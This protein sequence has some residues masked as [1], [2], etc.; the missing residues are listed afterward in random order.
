M[1]QNN[2]ERQWTANDKWKFSFQQGAINVNARREQGKPEPNFL[3][4][5]RELKG[6][7]VWD[8]RSLGFSW[9]LHHK[10]FMGRWFGGKNNNFLFQFLR[11]LSRI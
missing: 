3:V 11:E 10:V 5:L 2:K 4:L 1:V 8:I 9:F 7:Q 6:A